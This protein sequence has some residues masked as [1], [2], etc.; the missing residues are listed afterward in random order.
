MVLHTFVYLGV[1]WLWLRASCLELL[2]EKLGL[3]KKSF[4]GKCKLCTNMASDSYLC[5]D[6]SDCVYLPTLYLLYHLVLSGL[7]LY[8]AC[9]VK[10]SCLRNL[11]SL[12]ELCGRSLTHLH[13]IWHFFHGLWHYM[14]V[15]L[16]IHLHYIFGLWHYICVYLVIHLHYIWYYILGLWHYICVYL[17]VHL[18]YIWYYIYGL[19][20]YI[21]V[22]LVIH[23][24]YIWHYMFSLWHD[25]YVYLDALF[26][27]GT[28]FLD[29]KKMIHREHFIM[30][31]A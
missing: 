14:Y 13:F 16:V 31:S 15:Y 20:H 29:V 26:L 22:Y 7:L 8:I 5:N 10:F 30:W 9:I 17:L 4:G 12:R 27:I 6:G 23:L 19:W 18:H 11:H 21:C 25:M 3:T 28:S 24:H 1:L 2:P